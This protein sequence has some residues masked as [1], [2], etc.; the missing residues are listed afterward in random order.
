MSSLN[1]KI[2]IITGA[3]GGIGAATVRIFVERGATVI[4]SDLDAKSLEAMAAALR[5]DKVLTI[6]GDI[7]EEALNAELV[8]TAL[9]KFGRLDVAYLNAGIVGDVLPTHEYTTEGFER[10]MRINSTAVF[11]GLKHALR[12][13]LGGGGGSII[14]TSSVQ[15]L[16]A[17]GYTAGYTAS[18]HAVMGMVRTA[19]LEYARH[20][21]RINA[22]NPGVT[23]T[24]MMKSFAE[25]LGEGDPAPVRAGIEETVPMG[26][27]A[28]PEDIAHMVA[29]LAS[30]DSAYIT[31]MPH[32]VSGGMGAQ[33]TTP[34]QVPAN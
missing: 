17:C 28:R 13:M 29:F 21:I 4:A 26:R 33:W 20:N 2:A 6:A 16:Q 31:G 8:D 15:G 12:A 1:D 5:T 22:V 11:L 32:V 23:D 27:Y 9:D 24:N 10:V 34:M 7:T 18:K 19:A 25:D 14:C 30:D 3:A